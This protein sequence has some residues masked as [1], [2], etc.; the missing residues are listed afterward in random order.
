MTTVQ[1]IETRYAGCRFRSRVEA[2]H[3]VFFDKVGIPWLYEPEGFRLANGECYLPDFLLYPEDDAH[4]FWFEVKAKPPNREEIERCARLAEETKTDTY[5]Y[6]DPQFRAAP[7]QPG[8][9]YEDFFDDVAWEEDNDGEVRGVCIPKP[10]KQEMADTAYAFCGGK[11]AVRVLL[12]PPRRGPFWWTDCSHCD[13]VVLKLH[14]QV[15]TCP[16]LPDDE[17]PDEPYPSFQHR[18]RR[19]LR[20][21]M[22]ARSA[23][24]EHGETP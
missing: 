7:A 21:Y 16:F 8:V 24:F 19:L 11:L 1:A 18:T 17:R 15:G 14:G 2:R 5:L 13:R 20:G 23:R 12:G 6:F 4:R 22:A 3:A 9:K 10:W